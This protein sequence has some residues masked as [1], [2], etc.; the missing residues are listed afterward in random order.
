MRHFIIVGILVIAVTALT[1][2]GVGLDA[3]HLMPVEASVQA[4]EVDGMWDKQAMA[5]AFLFSLIAVPMFY[6]LIVF[7]RKKG[8]TT[9]A[10]HIEGHT[11]LEIAW[12]T[13]PLFAVLLFSYLGA[14]NLADVLR[15][16]PDAMV[17]KV[18]GS[19]WSWN[20]EYPDYGFTSPELY[21]P[22][23]KAVLFK[24]QSTDVIHS[25][26]VPEFRP[27]QDVVP[28]R[29]TE[30]RITP[31]LIGNY[32]VRCAELC[33]TAHYRMEQPVVVVDDQRFAAWVTEQQELAKK[34]QATPEGRG[35]KIYETFCK[36]CHSIDGSTG[37]APTWRGLYGSQVHLADGTT[38]TA[39]E[40]YILNSIKE[41]ESQVVNG[42]PPMSFRYQAAGIT[43]KQLDDILAYIKTLK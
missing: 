20:F 39:D 8:D 14:G 9:D 13:I 37:I 22:V 7:R 2:F 12:A 1:Y 40:E 34:Q 24:L 17:V 38:V 29:V 19:Q 31:N 36:A 23:N 33:G 16:S 28:G 5:M 10:Q 6:S 3:K 11:G 26:W 15:A 35:Q 21:L 32:K 41:P 27:K 4:S 18:T 42:F 43:D 25:F 30:L